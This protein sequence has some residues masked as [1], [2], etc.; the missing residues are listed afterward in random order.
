[1]HLSGDLFENQRE[2]EPWPER[3]APGTTLLHGFVTRDASA[4]LAE[5][6]RITEAAPFRRMVTPGGLPMSVAMSN[7]G[8]LGWVSDRSGYRYAPLDPQSGEHWPPMPAA[9][10]A[11]W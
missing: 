11:R 8:A 5:L 9:S 3:L 4:I 2:G 10:S 7:C 6:Q 1:M